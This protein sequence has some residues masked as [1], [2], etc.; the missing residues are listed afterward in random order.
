MR[1]GEKKEKAARGYPQ[2]LMRWRK[3]KRG[4]KTRSVTC[5]WTRVRG[6]SLRT[7]ETIR[8]E[9]LRLEKLKITVSK[10]NNDVMVKED[11]LIRRV[12]EYG[13]VTPARAQNPVWFFFKK[14]GSK[15]LKDD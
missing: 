10:K 4:G 9:K 15:K 13:L 8:L 14:Y 3:L 12:S 1:S 2:G 5:K 7:R 11:L 6:L